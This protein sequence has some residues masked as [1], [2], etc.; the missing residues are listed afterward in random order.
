[1]P[2]S[3]ALDA[4]VAMAEQL[5]TDE[6]TRLNGR[7]VKLEEP[8]TLEI[9]MESGKKGAELEFE[10]KWPK[11]GKDPR[12]SAGKGRWLFLGAMA[13]AIGA[14]AFFVTKK[15]RGSDKDADQMMESGREGLAL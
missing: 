15:V 1:M 9:E 10:I 2:L 14:T 5:K 13:A 3:E 11:E 6:T 7:K 12:R 4:V 8:V